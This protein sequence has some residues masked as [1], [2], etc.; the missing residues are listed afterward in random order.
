MIGMS[1]D[2]LDLAG[3]LIREGV[4]IG[5][6]DGPLLPPQELISRVRER[7]T[8][9]LVKGNAENPFVLELRDGSR[10]V[11]GAGEPSFTLRIVTQAGLQAISSF[12]ELAFAEAYMNGDIDIAGHMLSVFRCRGMLSDLHPL[13][14]LKATYLEPWIGG[15]VDSDKRWIKSHY[16]IDPEFFLLWLDK[17]IRGYSHAFFED[18]S[19][20]LEVAM[21]RKF[22]YAMDVTGM[23]PGWRVLDIGG[24]WGSFLEYGGSRGIQVTS[25]TISAESEKFMNELIRTKGLPGRAIRE[26]LLEYKTTER[27]DAIVNFGVSEH[28]PDYP[29]TVAQYERLLKPGRRLYLDAYS[30][31][32]HAM[33]SFVTRWVYEGNTSPLALP[34]YMEALRHTPFEVVLLQNDRNNYYLTCRKWAERLEEARETIVSRWGEFLYRRFHLYLW[35]SAYAFLAN[36]LSA[37]HMVLELPERQ[38]TA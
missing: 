37:H 16:D 9:F 8:Q 35:A 22:R 32:R 29:S 7:Y 19:E 33:P 6:S 38:R 21:E 2:W 5:A 14:Y 24:G 10:H 31:E 26:H 36:T 15:Q 27:Y 1:R 13:R 28:L 4:K 25:L 34:L 20:P 18:E 30:G 3:K 17:K 11:I 23:K 12:D